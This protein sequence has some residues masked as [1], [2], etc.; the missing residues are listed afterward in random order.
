MTTEAETETA[1]DAAGRFL[2]GRSGN[3]AG[4]PRG[5]RKLAGL[6]AEALHEGEEETIIRIVVETALAGDQVAARFCADRLLARP[7]GRRIALAL[8]K[9]ATAADVIPLFEAAVRAMAAGEITPEEAARVTHVLE[10]RKRAI[11]TVRWER[12]SGGTGQISRLRSPPL[13]LSDG[14]IEGLSRACY[15]PVFLQAE[16]AGAASAPGSGRRRSRSPPPSDCG[17]RPAAP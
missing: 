10:G 1:R 5:S 13:G 9:G 12:Y 16:Q 15:S 6:F 17:R 14:D 11:E 4:R 3:P 8:P 2:P 7:H